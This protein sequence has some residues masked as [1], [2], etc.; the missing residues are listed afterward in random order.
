MPY[1]G[2]FSSS[3]SLCCD[4]RELDSPE[5]IAVSG[6]TFKEANHER[7]EERHCRGQQ[8]QL[9]LYLNFLDVELQKCIRLRILAWS[10]KFEGM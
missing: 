8:G 5:D 3:H 1:R 9:A 4:D 7:R 2:T 6:D 10:I